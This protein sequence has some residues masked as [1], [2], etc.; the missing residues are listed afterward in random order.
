MLSRLYRS[1][2]SSN[3]RKKFPKPPAIL[4]M[5]DD[6]FRKP[7]QELSNAVPPFQKELDDHMSDMLKRVNGQYNLN[8]KQSAATSD[9]KP[10]EF[11][12]N[13]EKTIEYDKETGILSGCGFEAEIESYKERKLR[14]DESNSFVNNI[15]DLVTKM[16]CLNVFELFE[17]YKHSIALRTA[18]D[19]GLKLK[20]ELLN[21]ATKD[22]LD[23]LGDGAALSV[24]ELT[25]KLAMRVIYEKVESIFNNERLNSTHKYNK[26]VDA[27][28]NDPNMRAGQLVSKELLDKIYT[29]SKPE[30]GNSESQVSEDRLNRAYFK[31]KLDILSVFTD[32]PLDQEIEIKSG[33]MDFKY[34]FL[35]GIILKQTLEDGDDINQKHTTI[36]LK[37]ILGYN[38]IVD[39]IDSKI[40]VLERQLGL[41]SVK[42]PTKETIRH[43]LDIILHSLP[44]EVREKFNSVK[45]FTPRYLNTK[46]S[47]TKLQWQ[48]ID[49]SIPADIMPVKD[50][51]IREERKRGEKFLFNIMPEYRVSGDEAEKR[52]EREAEFYKDTPEMDGIPLDDANF[53]DNTPHQLK[54]NMREYANTT[55][56]R[57]LKLEDA[58]NVDDDDIDEGDLVEL[59]IAKRV[60]PKYDAIE[61]DYDAPNINKKTLNKT[62]LKKLRANRKITN[63]Y[64]SRPRIPISKL[65]L[66][67]YED[68]TYIRDI[69]TSVYDHIED[70]YEMD[71]IK[72]HTDFLYDEF[73][74]VI[75]NQY[76]RYSIHETMETSKPA[77]LFD[78]FFNTP[79][80]NSVEA[81]KL[82]ETLQRAVDVY[83]E[84]NTSM[85]HRH[86]L[87][88]LFK[89]QQMQNPLQANEMLDPEDDPNF[90]ITKLNVLDHLTSFS[91]HDMMTLTSE[92]L[93]E[94]K[95]DP[96]Y[97]EG[98]VPTYFGSGTRK[99][100]KAFAVVELPGTGKVTVNNR[101]F[102]EYFQ[103]PKDRSH[104]LKS[105]VSIGKT[106]EVDLK[107]YAHGGGATSQADAALVAISNALIKAFPE[108]E[109]FLVDRYFT[110][111]DK[112][113][114]E[115]K[116]TSKYKARKSYTYVRR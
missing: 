89:M 84:V 95:P 24:D 5:P 82:D 8:K 71:I 57:T 106:C 55:I 108:F 44:Q 22:I 113:R 18:R 10:I 67:S 13:L 88:R 27:I 52:A 58:D 69:S 46:Y 116:K 101:H 50:H 68:K 110:Y 35:Q 81:S 9:L 79:E 54:V 34:Q 1:K 11:Y 78:H 60:Q 80:A 96:M 76:G 86:Y 41:S 77:T 87:A 23:S 103:E 62:A 3:L 47:S 31:R 2:A 59:E 98:V 20:G 85:F 4:K 100:S 93:A 26:I 51:L 25:E 37:Q 36:K 63:L 61:R 107:V 111:I 83:K 53:E 99:R 112:R 64:G 72:D 33:Q 74:E 92:S 39:T 6:Y 109:R 21:V 15:N 115:R 7:R 19:L 32:L 45:P 29:I 43:Q 42:M 17:F 102:L 14:G 94:E 114:V 12:R 97:Y 49:L 16:N 70:E 73:F 40:A 75:R 65:A 38:E 104:M 48:N 105:V 90:G 91:A 66:C 30:V 28:M 56:S